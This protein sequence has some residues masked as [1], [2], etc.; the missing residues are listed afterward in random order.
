VYYIY[1]GDRAYS[2]VSNLWKIKR[3]K[4]KDEELN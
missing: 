1:Y 4:E 3:Q 2:Q